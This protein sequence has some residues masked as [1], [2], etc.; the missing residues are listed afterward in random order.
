MK[1]FW[2]FLIQDPLRKLIAL[3][4]TV[5]LFAVL[6][7]GKQLNKDINAV[8]LNVH[9]D[10]EVFLSHA[11]TVIPV[12]LSVRGSESRIKNLNTGDITGVLEISRNTPGFDSGTLHLPLSADNFVCPRGI[13]IIDID[14]KSVVLPVQRKI[15]REVAI[16]PEINGR[17]RQGWE[18]REVGC[19][20]ETVLVTGPERAVNN[21]SGIATEVLNIRPEETQTFSKNMPLR[22]PMPDEYT[23]NVASANVTVTISRQVNIRRQLDNIPVRWIFSQNK[24]LRFTPANSVSSVTLSGSQAAVG[25]ILPEN[26]LLYAELSDPM[27]MNPGEYE[28]TLQAVIK[29]SDGSVKIVSVKPDKIKVKCEKQ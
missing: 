11:N 27:H 17:P 13:E 26:I 1:S 15:S 5:V 9:C 29:N 24:S 12:R 20:P 25:K 18:L 4:L 2:Q 14:P 7:E 19:F 22:N 28:I 16:V 23:F 8:L 3:A 6:N 10:D 21:L